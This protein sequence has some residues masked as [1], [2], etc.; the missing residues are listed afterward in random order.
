MIV[1]CEANVR[2]QV[3]ANI[4]KTIQRTDQRGDQTRA[5]LIDRMDVSRSPRLL[6][7]GSRHILVETKH[8]SGSFVIGDVPEDVMEN[9]TPVRTISRTR[10]ELSDE[11]VRILDTLGTAGYK[12]VAMANTPDNRIVWTLAKTYNIADDEL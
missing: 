11:P 10:L 9:I 12:V 2:G 6:R 5:S 8:S 7:T 3:V 1:E 4:N